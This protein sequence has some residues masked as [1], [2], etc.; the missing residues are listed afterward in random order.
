MPTYSFVMQADGKLP[1]GMRET[2]GR[3]FPT[4]AGKKLRLTI[5]EAKDKRNLDQNAL[6]WSAIVPH[7]RQ[8]RF[9]AGD[10]VTIERT[11]ED[12]L[13]E[14]AARVETK[15]VDGTVIG[16][17]PMRSKEMSVREMAD[18]ITAVAAAMASFGCPIPVKGE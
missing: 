2:L 10:P 8:V 14:F 11:H 13:E 6:Y 4:Y 17:R 18:Y 7:V 5:E 16:T 3:V 12:L 1:P 9:D 15:R